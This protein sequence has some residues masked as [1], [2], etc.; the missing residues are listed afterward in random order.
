MASERFEGHS[1]PAIR[2]DSPR[3]GCSGIV[4]L[5]VK[6]EVNNDSAGK[7]PLCFSR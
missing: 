7:L 1:R 6:D 3:F 4:N 5:K 2:S